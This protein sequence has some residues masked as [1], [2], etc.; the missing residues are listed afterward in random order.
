MEF[1][2]IQNTTIYDLS[3]DISIV[4]KDLLYVARPNYV[5]YKV[6]DMI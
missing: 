5:K 1:A 6:L 4:G 3:S 2:E